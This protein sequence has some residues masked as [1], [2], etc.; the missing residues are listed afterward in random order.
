[1]TTVLLTENCLEMIPVAMDATVTTSIH[2][3]F[4]DAKLAY[5]LCQSI[6]GYHNYY[7]YPWMPQL[8]C[9]SWT[10]DVLTGCL[11]PTL[12]PSKYKLLKWST[13]YSKYFFCLALLSANALQ[14]FTERNRRNSSILKIM[15]CAKRVEFHQLWT[16]RFRWY[17]FWL[18][19][20]NT[21]NGVSTR[22]EEWFLHP[23]VLTGW[24]MVAS[25]NQLLTEIYR[26]LKAILQSAKVVAMCTAPMLK[27]LPFL[28]VQKLY[29]KQIVPT[30]LYHGIR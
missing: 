25:A 9:H 26:L 5:P 21:R 22:G 2:G 7:V 11:H 14:V 3:P 15:Q 16:C 27:P 1:M 17:P 24:V 18:A 13:P 23:F 20:I 28:L 29:S 6:R 8:L 10:L 30:R 12:L 19:S 4:I